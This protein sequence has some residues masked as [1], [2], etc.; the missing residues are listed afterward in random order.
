M[1]NG[2]GTQLLDKVLEQAKDKGIPA[3]ADLNQALQLKPDE[4][5]FYDSRGFAYAG[6]K[7]YDRAIADYNQA[8]KLKPDADYTYYHRGIVYR[9]LGDRLQAIADFRKALELA[10]NPKQRQDAE[11]Q[12]QELGAT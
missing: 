11:K 4:A 6:K 1:S 12:L 5:N 10:K 3:I 8:L 2:F 7:D 9:A